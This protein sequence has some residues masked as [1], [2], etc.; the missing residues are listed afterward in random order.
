MDGPRIQFR[1]AICVLRAGGDSKAGF[2]A[3]YFVVVILLTVLL[4]IA[5]A[6]AERMHFH[7]ADSWIVLLGM[8]MVFWAGGIRLMLAGLQQ[9]LRP[10]FTAARIF[11]ITSDDPLPI[12]QEL[13]FANISMGLIAIL[14]LPEKQMLLPAAI[15]TGLYYGLAGAKHV[16]NGGRNAHRTVAMLTDIW[17]FAVIAAFV[18]VTVL[19]VKM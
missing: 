11:G 5:S 16:A 18:A 3:M 2:T 17:I 7:S 12:V 8:W 6:I 4:P 14:S 13:G 10:R 19:N 9:S 1:S 15:V